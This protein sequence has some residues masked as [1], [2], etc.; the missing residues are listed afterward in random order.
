MARYNVRKII[1]LP[2]MIEV[3]GSKKF[4]KLQVSDDYLA[5]WIKWFWSLPTD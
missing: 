4:H 5:L 1:N 3:L 2:K